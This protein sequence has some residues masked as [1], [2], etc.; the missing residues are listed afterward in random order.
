M[1]ITGGV[2]VYPAE[3]EGLLAGHPKVQDVAVIGVPDDEWGESVKAIV[4]PAP[5]VDPTPE[6][7]D[8]LIEHCR[9]HLAHYKCPRSIDF[10]P[11]LPRTEAGKLYKREIRDEYWAAAGR[12]I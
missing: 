8:E 2:N 1:I 9:S 6:L 5:G 4:Q 3:V 11:D 10:R 7:A 12:Q